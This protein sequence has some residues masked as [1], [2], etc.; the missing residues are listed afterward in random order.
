TERRATEQS[1]QAPARVVHSHAS[2]PVNDGRS[3]RSTRR[4]IV[5]TPPRP[6][7][8]SQWLLRGK[9]RRFPRPFG[10]TIAN[11]AGDRS[12]EFLAHLNYITRLKHEIVFRPCF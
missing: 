6:H 2:A 4:R 3:Y 5:D 11:P 9:N 10:A 7:W 8:P 12:K 1:G